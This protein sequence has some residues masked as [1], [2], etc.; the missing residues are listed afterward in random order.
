MGH[1]LITALEDSLHQWGKYYFIFTAM[2][3]NPST[4]DVATYIIKNGTTE[5]LSNNHSGGGNSNG[6]Q[7]NDITVHA[8]VNMAVNDWVS[9]RM[10]ANS[11]ATCYF[12]GATGSKYGS[13]SG[14]LIG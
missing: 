6:H 5:V 10:V 14:F 13:F 1:I 11:S 9:A 2:F 7:W 4:N 12:Y 3:T 8:I